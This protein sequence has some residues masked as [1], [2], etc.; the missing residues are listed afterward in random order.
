MV[1]FP[2]ATAVSGLDV[3][4]WQADDG[5]CGGSP[6][7]HLTCTEAYVT[8]SGEGSLQ[9]LTPQGLQEFPL[10]AGKVVW[11]GPGTIH[12]AVNGDGSLRVIV[13]MQNSGLP[14]AGDAV[15]TYPPHILAD[16]A[17]Y[18]RVRTPRQR[19][20]LAVQGFRWLAGDPSSLERFYQQAL[21]LVEDR[22]DDWE[23]RWQAGP[24]EAVRQ[25][26]DQLKALRAGDIGYL[27][28]GEVR[29][30]EAP[31]EKAFGMCGMLDVHRL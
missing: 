6:H 8:I 22:L 15:L 11:F 14:E 30:S 24:A 10:N 26:G 25:T 17:Q 1:I 31:A 3:Y 16:P 21:A 18:H 4:P 13:V 9:T 27:L 29:T 2:G 5:R 12:R 7:M 20:D 23:A 28:Q 19:R